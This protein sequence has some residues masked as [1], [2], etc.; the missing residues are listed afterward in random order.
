MKN[1]K[2]LLIA[3]LFLG[4]AMPLMSQGAEETVQTTEAEQVRESD[5]QSSDSLEVTQGSDTSKE[6]DQKLEVEV[7][8]PKIEEE[9]NQ[10]I[11]EKKGE[12][13]PVETTPA[14][15]LIR[16]ILLSDDYGITK[17]ELAKYSDEQL[18][19]T[20]TLFTRYNYDISGMDYGAY[21]RLLKTLFEDQSVN[22]NDAL[23][24]LYF[25][26]SSYTS[27]SSMIPDVEKLKTYLDTLYPVNSTFIAGLGLTSEQLV[28]RL[29]VLQQMEDQLIAKGEALSFG[30]VAGLISKDIVPT[31]PTTT[32]TTESSSEVTNTSNLESNTVDLTKETKDDKKL[33][34]TSEEKIPS[35]IIGLTLI[36]LMFSGII[37]YRFKN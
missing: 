9:V 5:I 28:E 31:T 29:T 14:P 15:S 4:M 24:Q 26:P 18:E 25:D 16:E 19:Q 20:M 22:A 17:E 35:N 37:L 12:D 11:G 21:A 27:Y 8:A 6:A 7:V 3:G 1:F 10:L 30:R 13:V 33:P 32:S 34:K 2:P 36:G 23:T